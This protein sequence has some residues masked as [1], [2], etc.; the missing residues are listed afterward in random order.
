MNV[1]SVPG[2]LAVDMMN[3]AVRGLIESQVCDSANPAPKLIASRTRKLERLRALRHTWDG[4]RVSS[5]SL[6]V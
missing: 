6:M 3:A 2:L 1:T 5:F 4:G